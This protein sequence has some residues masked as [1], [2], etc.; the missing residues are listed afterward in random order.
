MAVPAAPAAAPVPGRAGAS[1]SSSESAAAI[2]LLALAPQ[3]PP[4]APSPSAP[5]AQ[6]N[7]GDLEDAAAAPPQAAGPPA[8]P[9]PAAVPQQSTPM[10]I[11]GMPLFLRPDN[12]AD[13]PGAKKSEPYL[14]IHGTL[15]YGWCSCRPSETPSSTRSRPHHLTFPE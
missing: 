8:A 12:T 15:A 9:A 4:S 14:L 6:N 11:S 3:T 2:S 1:L 13:L 10:Q 7:S 5:P